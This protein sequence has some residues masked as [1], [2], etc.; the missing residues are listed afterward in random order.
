MKF[1]PYGMNKS[2]KPSNTAKKDVTLISTKSL[3]TSVFTT[4][5]MLFSILALTTIAS[6]IPLSGRQASTLSK[7]KAFSLYINITSVVAL[8]NVHFNTLNG[9]PVS[10]NRLGPGANA[11]TA[12][13]KASEGGDAPGAVWWQNGTAAGGPTILSDSG[14][15]YYDAFAA[16]TPLDAPNLYSVALMRHDP[17]PGFAIKSGMLTIPV[18][19]A[20]LVVCD[21]QFGAY[22]HPQWLFHIFHKTSDESFFNTYVFETCAAVDLIA[23]CAEEKKLPEAAMYTR[24][25]AMDVECY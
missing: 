18:K 7:S 20:Q 10:K 13:P 16:S 25:G 11:L 12:Y 14:L 24:D 6:A 21:H 23:K 15:E 3:I 8:Q 4:T 9:Q 5:R 22:T 2:N 1:H 19:D 17:T